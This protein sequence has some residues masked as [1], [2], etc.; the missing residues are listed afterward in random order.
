MREGAWCEDTDVVV[1]PFFVIIF[2]LI[3][4]SSPMLL[5]LV[6][7]SYGVSQRYQL[8]GGTSRVLT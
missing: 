3:S 7:W 6:S 8:W 5:P 2:I 1:E 4:L